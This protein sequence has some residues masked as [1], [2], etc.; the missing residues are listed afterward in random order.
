MYKMNKIIIPILTMAFYM[1][2]AKSADVVETTDNSPLNSTEISRSVSNNQGVQDSSSSKTSKSLWNDVLKLFKVEEP[3]RTS[4]EALSTMLKNQNVV[5][6]FSNVTDFDQNGDAKM[7]EYWQ[8]L[9]STDSFGTKSPNI[10][11]NLSNTGVSVE[12]ISKWSAEFKKAGKTV[13]WNLS[14]N[15]NLGDNVIDAIDIPSV[16]SLNLCGTSVTDVGLAK[17]AASLETNGIC[18]LVCIHLS[19][20]GVTE[21]GVASLKVAIQK[22]VESW[23]IKNPGKELKLQG[24]DGSGVI[25]EKIP[26]LPKQPNVNPT[27]PEIAEGNAMSATSVLTIESP[28]PKLDSTDSS[29]TPEVAAGIAINNADATIASVTGSDVSVPSSDPALTAS[30]TSLF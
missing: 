30:A 20:S 7:S 29:S 13:I 12:F 15:K 8:Q 5:I 9:V 4:D 23:R 6:D 10:Y 17:V 21:S 26:S 22:A 27:Q 25:Y 18:N 14:D 2:T 24:S 19:D 16:Y 1:F 3:S 28:T 11:V